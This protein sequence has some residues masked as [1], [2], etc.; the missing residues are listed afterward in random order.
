SVSWQNVVSE[1]VTASGSTDTGS[2]LLGYQRETSTD[3]G[4]T[5]TAPVSASSLTVTAEGEKLVRFR[6][7]DVSGQG[8]NWG[9]AT[10]RI[11]R[12]APDA[13]VVAG[14]SAAWQRAASV[15]VTASGTADTGGS[16]WD[17]YGYKV[18]TDGGSTWTPEATGALYTVNSEGT[19]LVKF[20]SYDLAG[21]AS[22]WVT[23]TVN[24]D[25][26]APTDPVVSGGSASWQNVASI[27]LKAGGSTDGGSGLSGY[28][29]QIS[30]DGG[31]TWGA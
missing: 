30:T 25:N 13:P 11:D 16:G 8:S 17:H 14:G 15:D 19:T 9:S 18:S 7:I 5:W 10:M 28:Q 27:I 1:Q 4:T 3:G 6:S 20:R 29:R 24:L 21:N 26:T 2:G 12:T 22:A 23:A 31:V